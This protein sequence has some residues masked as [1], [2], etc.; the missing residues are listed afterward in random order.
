MGVRSMIELRN[1][2]KICNC[3]AAG[4]RWDKC[5]LCNQE[6]EICAGCGLVKASDCEHYD[7]N[8][9]GERVIQSQDEHDA[10]ILNKFFAGVPL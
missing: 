7:L 9:Q 6:V 1:G 2:K 5:D 4:F 3:G 8:V 10:E